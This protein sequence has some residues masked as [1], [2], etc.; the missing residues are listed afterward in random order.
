MRETAPMRNREGVLWRVDFFIFH[1]L[2]LFWCPEAR[3]V[4]G[5]QRRKVYRGERLTNRTSA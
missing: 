3:S 1:G 2:V 4:P 5:A